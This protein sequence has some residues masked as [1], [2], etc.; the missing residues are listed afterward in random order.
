MMKRLPKAEHSE[1]HHVPGK[2]EKNSAQGLKSGMSR[3]PG[4]GR[5]SCQASWSRLGQDRNA[6]EV[7]EGGSH[8][9]M[10]LKVY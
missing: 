10:L 8:L 5:G 4:E 7:T 9:S 6:Q 3:S 2:Q 1:E